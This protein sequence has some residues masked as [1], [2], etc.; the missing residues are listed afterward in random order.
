MLPETAQY[1]S[2]APAKGPSGALGWFGSVPC[3][4][5]SR[6]KAASF[7]AIAWCRNLFQSISSGSSIGTASLF[8]F[9]RCQDLSGRDAISHWIIRPPS[10]A[11]FVDAIE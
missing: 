4:S 8:V 11:V 10:A 2:V 7:P 6:T 3:A 1:S 9:P 5:A